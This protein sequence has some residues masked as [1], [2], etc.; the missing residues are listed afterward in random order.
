MMIRFHIVLCCL[1]LVKDHNLWCLHLMLT[2]RIR[3]DSQ[4]ATVQREAVRVAG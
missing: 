3:H 4:E 2:G 1:L